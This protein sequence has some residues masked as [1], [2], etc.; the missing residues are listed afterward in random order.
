MLG[1]NHWEN[2]LFS[3]LSRR[4]KPSRCRV[5][6]TATLMQSD[7]HHSEVGAGDFEDSGSNGAVAC[8][9]FAFQVSEGMFL[10]VCAS[11]IFSDSSQSIRRVLSAWWQ[12]P[13][14]G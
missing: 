14:P 13:T 3:D 1:T 10:A 9:R 8:F 6:G 7:R 4:G 2:A 5:G 12:P 11:V